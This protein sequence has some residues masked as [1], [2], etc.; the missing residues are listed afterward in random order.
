MF[1]AELEA[2]VSALLYIKSTTKRNKLVLVTQNPYR[3]PC[4]A[5]GI[6]PQFRLL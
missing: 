6:I 2:I 1:T 3:M 5:S 4:C